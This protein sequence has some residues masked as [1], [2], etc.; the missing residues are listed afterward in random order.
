MN[1]LWVEDFGGRASNPN[2][3]ILA[4]FEELLGVETFDRHIDEDE[5]LDIKS[6]PGY[7]SE[8]CKQHSDHEVSL[9]LNYCDFIEYVQEKDVLLDFDAVIIDINLSEGGR[10][11]E[12]LPKEFK[13][14]QGFHNKAGF[15]VFNQLNLNGFDQENTCFFTAETEINDFNDNCKAIL[16]SPPHSFTKNPD[17]YKGARKFINKICSNPFFSIRRFIISSVQE[18]LSDTDKVFS[19]PFNDLDKKTFLENLLW[20][21]RPLSGEKNCAQFHL[22]ICEYLTKPFERFTLRDLVD[23]KFDGRDLDFKR[24]NYIPLYFLRNWIAHGL[25]HYTELDHRDTYFVFCLTLSC[26]FGEFWGS[27]N[28]Q[29]KNSELRFPSI[30]NKISQTLFLHADQKDIKWSKVLWNLLGVLRIKK[31]GPEFL[32]AISKKGDKRKNQAGWKKEDYRLLFY[33]SFLLSNTKF[34]TLDLD[35]EHSGDSVNLVY[36]YKMDS[37]PLN[38]IAYSAIR[39]LG[40]K[41]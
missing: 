19:G 22:S 20:M 3:I 12:A 26:L 38:Y 21:A 33:A 13:D 36:R 11:E 9:I 40:V 24:C 27:N 39:E 37:H 32:W 31:K 35:S 16:F 5:V 23:S 30:A 29:Q 34:N 25:L 2:K 4:L 18:L 7:F 8:F 17:G 6:N 15:Y 1:V 14:I 28:H 10:A 41:L